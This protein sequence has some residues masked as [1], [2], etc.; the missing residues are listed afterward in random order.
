MN[1]L[2]SPV[3]F[4]SAM[5]LFGCSHAAFDRGPASDPS[6]VTWIA[7]GPGGEKIARAI[8]LS[9]DTCPSLTAGTEAVSM[10]TR[11]MPTADG[12]FPGMVC[13]APITPAMS[14]QPLSINGKTLAPISAHPEKILIL[15]DTGCRVKDQASGKVQVQNCNDPKKGWPFAELAAAAARLHPDLVIHV[16]DYHYREA[17][18]PAGNGKCAGSPYGDAWDSW[19]ADFFTPALPLLAAAPWIF[20]RG[21]H[22]ICSRAQEGFFRFLDPRPLPAACEAVTPPYSVPFPD[23]TIAVLDSAAANPTAASVASL[24]QLSLKNAWLATHRP[25]WVSAKE[26]TTGDDDGDDDDT[27]LEDA[28][29]LKPVGPVP[30]VSLVLTG[31]RHLFRALSFADHRAQQITAGNGG[32]ALEGHPSM[33]SEGTLVD[34]GSTTLTSVDIRVDFGFIMI[35]RTGT[36]WLMEIFDKKAH[37]VGSRTLDL[38]PQK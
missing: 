9:G 13:E 4:F 36:S 7:I 35:K 38:N 3:S 29:Q 37:W 31:H 15:G 2:I 23:F 12:R 5:L 32:T 24:S 34:S 26:A 30:N 21:N 18:C 6:L 33:D 1:K 10:Q 27:D 17:A 20:V 28:K 14:A 16:G 11:A 8:S 19:N 22:E 25:L